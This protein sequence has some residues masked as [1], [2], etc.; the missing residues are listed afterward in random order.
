MVIQFLS[1]L[2]LCIGALHVPIKVNEVGTLLLSQCIHLFE[3]SDIWFQLG[4]LWDAK[5]SKTLQV[6]RGQCFGDRKFLRS[7][8]I[9]YQDEVTAGSAA[10]VREPLTVG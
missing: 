8:E 10:P 6:S 7:S 5:Y 1:L 9:T 4:M 3:S 2:D